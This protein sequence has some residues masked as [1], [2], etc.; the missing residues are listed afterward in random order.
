MSLRKVLPGLY[1]ALLPQLLFAAVPEPAALV[2][3]VALPGDVV[4]LAGGPLDPS[5]RVVVAGHLLPPESLQPDH[6]TFIVPPFPE[7]EYLV[8]LQ[9]AEGI[10]RSGFNLR[11]VAPAPIIDD[12]HPPALDLCSLREGGAVEVRGRHFATGSRLLLDQ[13]AVPTQREDGALRFIPPPGLSPGLHQIQAINPDGKR[14]LPFSLSV[15]GSPEIHQVREG[16]NFVNAYQL[17]IEGQNFAFGST[18]VVDGQPLLR[19]PLRVAPADSV[20]FVDCRT[21][22]Y[23]RYPYSQQLKR[24]HLQVVNPGGHQSAIF[25]VTVP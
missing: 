6:L 17:I 14:S 1:L 3:A 4:T 19:N 24:L 10:S 2:P 20:E 13:A 21:L 22:I 7:G 25:G 5:V 12:L 9:N 11:I 8:R 18:L 16:D 15:D 23:T